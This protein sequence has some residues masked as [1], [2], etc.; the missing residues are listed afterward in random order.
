MSVYFPPD[1]LPKFDVLLLGLG[2]D[3]HTCSLF[4]NHKL[5]D[6]TSLWVC[7]INDSPKPPLSRITF[8]FP[9]INNA[10]ACIFAVLGS[11]KAKI[12]KVNIIYS[13][14]I[15]Y[16]SRKSLLNFLLI[17]FDFSTTPTLTFTIFYF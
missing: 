16:F 3:G 11:S 1:S 7:P 15:Y 5:L 6:E 12:I 17:K 2:P 9:V 8:T 4:P 13:F 10:R 14:T